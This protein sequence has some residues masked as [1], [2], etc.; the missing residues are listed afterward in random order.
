MLAYN[1]F[2][3]LV[4][5]LFYDGFR[6]EFEYTGK[7]NATRS[8]VLI[9]NQIKVSIEEFGFEEVIVK[10]E[11]RSEYDFIVYYNEVDI[12]YKKLHDAYVEI[13]SRTGY[14]FD[15]NFYKGTR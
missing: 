8:I 7:N 2:N 9:H 15:L 1:W 12:L 13:A 11:H 6:I 3:V 14:F 4:T 10:F 5:N